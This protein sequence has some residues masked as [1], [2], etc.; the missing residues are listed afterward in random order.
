MTTGE[1]RLW[2]SLSNRQLHGHR[3]RRQHPLGHYIVD[4]VCL[5]R[6]VIVEIDGPQHGE[7]AQIAHDARRTAWLEAEGY[8]VLR[9]WANEIDENLDSVLDVILAELENRPSRE[10]GRDTPTSPRQG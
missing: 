8:V 7:S 3:F 9:F 4:F 2:R 6:R 1:W 10:R 5:D